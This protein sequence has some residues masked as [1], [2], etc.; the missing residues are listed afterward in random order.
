MTFQPPLLAAPASVLTTALIMILLIRSGR[1]ARFHRQRGWNAIVWGFA[2]LLAGHL[3]TLPVVRTSYPGLAA[4]VAFLGDPLGFT[5]IAVGLWRWLP[6]LTE[7]VTDDISVHR[8]IGPLAENS[9]EKPIWPPRTIQRHSQP[10]QHFIATMSHEIRAPLNR[11]LASLNLLNKVPLAGESRNYLQQSDNAARILMF[12]IN[13]VL[14][15][16]RIETGQL[17][18]DCIDFDLRPLLDDISH[19]LGPVAADKGIE[20]TAFIPSGLPTA[21]RGD[22]N[23]LQQ[24]V[25]NLCNHAIQH[26]PVGGHLE[27]HAGPTSTDNGTIEFLFEVRDTGPGIPETRHKHLFA[28]DSPM[29]TEPPVT[30]NGAVKFP[31]L[32]LVVSGRLVGLMAGE[33]DIDDNPFAAS[34]TIFH[35]TAR[36][37]KQP[38]ADEQPEQ[39]LLQGQRVLIVASRGLQLALLQDALG[40]W[41]A[42]FGHVE[43]PGSAWATLQAAQHANRP[44]QMVIVN[45]SPGH[46]NGLDLSSIRQA[47]ANASILLLC[48]RLD[49]H[50]VEESSTANP[51]LHLQKPFSLD[52][53]HTVL[54]RLLR[55]RTG[56]DQETIQPLGADEDTRSNQLKILL[57]DDQSA[58]LVICRAMLVSLGCKATNIDSVIN[59]SQ[60][61][62]LIKRTDYDLVFMDYQMPEMNGIETT[63]GIRTWEKE[64]QRRPVSIIAVCMEDS[65]EDRKRFVQAGFDYVLVK[66]MVLPALKKALLYFLE[67]RRMEKQAERSRLTRPEVDLNVVMNRIGVSND[68]F[69]PIARTLLTQV[70]DLFRSIDNGIYLQD[71]HM[72]KTASHALGVRLV[73]LFPQFESPIVAFHK[74]L[75]ELD[76]QASARIQSTLRTEY[77]TIQHAMEH[78]VDQVAAE[79]ES[80]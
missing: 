53:L 29:A 73:N 55:L 72:T 40:K 31:N 67:R 15:Y 1:Q 45:Q 13:N 33:I 64:R 20:M 38:V 60:A 51:F 18:L 59:G 2:S 17:R 34:G 77:A 37:Q 9:P 39:S 78:L 50:M 6:T 4:A 41:G 70:P 43:E 28:H 63:R 75:E 65:P 21:L 47:A 36:F 58:N 71:P 66:P 16:S 5:L 12:A 68:K 57:V 46:D 7:P 35:F 32:G 61:I 30:D 22:P 74:S 11:V 69:I 79:G 44:Y 3:A 56:G 26:T 14:D 49:H 52:R 42:S 10:M 80:T 62:A 48:N 23:R 27:L 8:T 76:W 25:F 54:V 19:L 24:I